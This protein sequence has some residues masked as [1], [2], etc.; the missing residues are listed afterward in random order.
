MPG[1]KLTEIVDA[2]Q[3][4][5]K[6]KLYKRYF[7]DYSANKLGYLGDCKWLAQRPHIPMALERADENDRRR[8]EKLYKMAPRDRYVDPLGHKAGKDKR[9]EDIKAFQKANNLPVQQQHPQFQ[10]PPWGAY[11]QHPAYRYDIFTG[12]TQAYGRLAPLMPHPWQASPMRSPRASSPVNLEGKAFPSLMSPT[13]ERG[14]M[15]GPRVRVNGKNC[16]VG[17]KS[18]P[19]SL[20]KEDFDPKIHKKEKRT[21]V[22]RIASKQRLETITEESS[23]KTTPQKQAPKS[24]PKKPTAKPAQQK[25]AAKPTQEKTAGVPAKGLDPVQPAVLKEIAVSPTATPASAKAGEKDA[26]RP[27]TLSVKSKSEPLPP[28][29]RLFL[30]GDMSLAVDSSSPSASSMSPQGRRP[31][32]TATRRRT[33]WKDGKLSIV[34]DS[35]ELLLPSGSASMLFQMDENYFATPENK[36]SNPSALPK[37]TA[38]ATEDVPTFKEEAQ[39]TSMD[40][41]DSIPPRSS[42]GDAEDAALLPTSQTQ[43]DSKATKPKTSKKDKQTKAKETVQPP[44]ARRLSSFSLKKEG[45]PAPPEKKVSVTFVKAGR[46]SFS[47]E[48]KPEEAPGGKKKPP[49]AIPAL[50]LNVITAPSEDLKPSPSP[51][52]SPPAVEAYRPQVQSQPQIVLPSRPL[53]TAAGAD[54]SPSYT[55][56][57]PQVFVPVSSQMVTSHLSPR[58]HPQQYHQQQ[59]QYQQYAAAYPAASHAGYTN[60]QQQAEYHRQAAAWYAAGGSAG[61]VMASPRS[62]QAYVTQAAMVS[63][64]YAHTQGTAGWGAAQAQQYGWY[65]P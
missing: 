32:G 40:P 12:S 45:P 1:R 38:T 10:H 46:S 7:V 47:I 25:E 37:E 39:K 31:S 54:T 21:I 22:E 11:G 56:T 36:D 3:R 27:R 64:R 9:E 57:Q 51:S 19:P 58:K 63:P 55:Q 41:P 62:Q 24:T 5:Y 15:W 26:D 43:T 34:P 2:V 14:D 33:V 65:H 49:I 4:K 61:Y 6:V 18:P 8:H 16:V 48:S 59:Q 28:S 44:P 53:I 23:R 52:P 35:T 60:A 42:P 20:A 13:A 29:P 50:A 30:E 17:T